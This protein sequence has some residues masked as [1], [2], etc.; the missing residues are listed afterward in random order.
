MDPINCLLSS[1]PRPQVYPPMK[2]QTNRT[3]KQ[4]CQENQ[5][6]KN[7]HIYMMIM[8]RKRSQWFYSASFPY[9]PLQSFCVLRKN[10]QIHHKVN[11]RRTKPLF[12]FFLFKIC[13]DHEFL[14]V[15][16]L[17]IFIGSTT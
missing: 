9:I 7:C 3:K 16:I 2:T 4:I 15:I 6:K 13:Q 8:I 14:L 10:L 12:F 11:R 1:F 5:R 17:H